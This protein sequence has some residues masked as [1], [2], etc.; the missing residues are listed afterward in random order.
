M[1][2][3]GKRALV[4][5]ASGAIGAAIAR[6]LAADGASLLLH[7]NSRRDAIDAMLAACAKAC[8]SDRFSSLLFAPVETSE[9]VMLDTHAKAMAA[10]KAGPG[11]FPV[12]LTS[13]RRDRGVR[14]RTRT[15]SAARALRRAA[16][17]LTPVRR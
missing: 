4:T 13:P 1:S 12:G 3:D 8:G 6:R 9:P 7:A 17:A 2:L 16:R 14:A 10:M 15:P 5:G 11:D